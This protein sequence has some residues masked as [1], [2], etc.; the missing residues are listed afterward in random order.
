VAHNPTV[1]VVEDDAGISD[2]VAYA[3]ER[4]G[5]V[6]LRAGT[7][8]GARAVESD[9]DVVVLDLGLPDGSGFILLGEWQNKRVGRGVIVLT[10]RDDE[11]DCVAALEAGADDFVT[12]PFSVRAL[13]ARVRAVLRRNG[14]ARPEAR[15][16]DALVVDKDRRA[17]TYAGRDLTLTKIE[18]DVLEALAAAPGRVHTRAQLVTRVWG[19]G[20]SLTERTVDSHVKALRKKLADVGADGSMIVAVRGVGFKLAEAGACL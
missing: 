2:A 10:S 3:V 13:V 6:A 5:M 7:L 1:L 8:E 12:K 20:F 14:H 15:G 11:V 17:A 9:A 18:F 16:N 4:D 19:D